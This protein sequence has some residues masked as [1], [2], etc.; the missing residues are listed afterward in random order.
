M[1]L[2]SRSSASLFVAV[3][4]LSAFWACGGATEQAPESV[5]ADAA[6]PPPVPRSCQAQTPGADHH[7]G[8]GHDQDC[9]ASP[10]VPGGTYNRLN[11]AQFPATVSPFRM[12]TFEVTVGRLRQFVNAYPVSWPNQNDGANPHVPRSGWRTNWFTAATSFEPNGTVGKEAVLSALRCD[13]ELLVG[14]DE[15][16]RGHQRFATWTDDPNAS[17]EVVPANCLSWYTAF[18]FCAW[19]GGRLPTEAEYLYVAAGGEEQRRYPWGDA[20]WD[21]E[22]AEVSSYPAF[23]V[24]YPED[25]PLEPVGSRPKG[26]S[27]W[28]QL[29]MLGGVSEPLLDASPTQ[30]TPVPLDFL[31]PCND[32]L[33][34]RVSADGADYRRYEVGEFDSN[35]TSYDSY[36]NGRGSFGRVD[37]GGVGNGVRCVRDP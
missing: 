22:T 6:P 11:N 23:H 25:H 21:T 8:I 15:D 31:V 19:D 33:D 29:D 20:S 2:T 16:P 10:L 37:I 24:P 28:G 36:T 35:P 14:P 17:S 30:T 5:D 32:C 13:Y 27:R 1:S 18:A 9:C 34:S 3:S 4:A 7:C 26:A 12:D